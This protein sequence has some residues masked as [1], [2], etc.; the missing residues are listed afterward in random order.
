MNSHGPQSTSNTKEVLVEIEIKFT[1]LNLF[2]YL[3]HSGLQCSF[4]PSVT[5]TVR[6]MTN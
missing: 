6:T 1:P 5:L 3:E 4:I 2:Y